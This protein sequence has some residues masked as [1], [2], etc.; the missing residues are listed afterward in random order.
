MVWSSSPAAPSRKSELHLN[1]TVNV[2]NL[3]FGLMCAGLNCP[4]LGAITPLFQSMPQEAQQSLS[5][6]STTTPYLEEGSQPQVIV[7][8]SSRVMSNAAAAKARP[9]MTAGFKGGINMS[10]R[11]S[12]KSGYV[13]PTKNA[14]IDANCETPTTTGCVVTEK[15]KETSDDKSEIMPPKFEGMSTPIQSGNETM[16]DATRSESIEVMVVDSEVQM[17]QISETQQPGSP[18]SEE[19]QICKAP[20]PP[21]PHIEVN[22]IKSEPIAE[23]VVDMTPLEI[24]PT[25]GVSHVKDTPNVDL[26]VVVPNELPPAPAQAQAQPWRRASIS[27]PGKPCT[28]Q[29]KTCEH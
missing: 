6:P 16:D 11:S 12:V 9:S 28:M 17:G 21:L 23:R 27:S 24:D 4:G 22:E 2:V 26:V 13:T 7:T 10:R 1:Y 15:I 14:N 25:P 20:S 3:T 29:H 19:G 5:S 8:E 18:R